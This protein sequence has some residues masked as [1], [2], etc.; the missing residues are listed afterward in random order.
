MKT[1]VL[2]LSFTAALLLLC[3]CSGGLFMSANKLNAIAPGMTKEEVVDLM[4]RP[5]FR[6]FH[7]DIEEW[8]YKRLAPLGVESQYLYVY[9]RFKDNRV[10]GMETLTEGEY[11][12]LYHTPALGV[13]PPLQGDSAR[14]GI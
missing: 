4:G 3:G 2:F 5:D 6:N 14:I 1:K 9:I 11:N 12:R 8:R 13:L 10:I 7:M